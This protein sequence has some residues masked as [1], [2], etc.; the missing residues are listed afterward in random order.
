M[1]FKKGDHVICEVKKFNFGFGNANQLLYDIEIKKGIISGTTLKGYSGIMYLVK[2]N[3]GDQNYFYEDKITL[4]L[5]KI[6]EDKLNEL[7]I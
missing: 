3:N 1:K 6:R 2:C 7:G 4:D 5:I